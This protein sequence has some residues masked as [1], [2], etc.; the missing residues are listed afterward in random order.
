MVFEL[1]A[2]LAAIADAG[3]AVGFVGLA[4]AVVVVGIR[5]YRFLR[6]AI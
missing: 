3:E 5:A 6:S 4:V 2:L 1:A